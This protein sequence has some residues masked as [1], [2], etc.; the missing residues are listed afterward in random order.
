MNSPF[1]VA[2]KKCH[3]RQRTKVIHA[4]THIP[5]DKGEEKTFLRKN[6][7]FYFFCIASF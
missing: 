4:L 1:F 5:Y 7:C 3:T 6:L 2:L